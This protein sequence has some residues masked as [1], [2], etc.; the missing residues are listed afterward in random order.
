VLPIIAS[1]RRLALT[2]VLVAGLAV[3][4]PA[5]AS[6]LIAR[7]ARDVTLRVNANGQALLGY[8]AKGKRWDVLAWGAINAVHPSPDRRQVAFRLDYSG[9]WATYRKTL[10]SSFRNVCGRYTG[11]QL[12]WFL[13][14]C[15]M[16]D[17]T[18]WAVQ[19]WQR[20]LPN[21]GFEPWKPLQ[22]SRELRLSRWSAELPKLELFTNWAYSK[23]FHH[24]FG[25]F[26]WLGQPVYGFGATSTG[27]PTDSFGRNIYLDTLNSA[28]GPGW[29][30]ENS[31][32]AHHGTGVFCYG[33]YPHDPYPGYP[34][35]GRRPEGK[36]ERYRATAIGPGV[37][38]D[39]TWEGAAPAAYDEALDR[40]LVEA[41][42]ALYAGDKLCKPV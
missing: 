9:G 36:G 12:A 21:L 4:A 6:Q 16:P 18:H 30:R 37:M 3:P 32:L 17:G 27:A 40:Q 22:A 33:F 8:T 26:S 31:F 11:P 39:V 24:L 10:S 15:T 29:R 2:L 41:Q 35:A 7:D 42:R 23:R 1:M 38:P 34:A 14:G 20:G 13:I 19:S 5:S 25:R 28:Y